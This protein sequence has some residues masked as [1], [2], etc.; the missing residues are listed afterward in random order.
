MGEA[1]VERAVCSSCGVDVWD[2]TLFCYN[3]G[4]RV[5]PGRMSEP[6]MVNGGAA[7]TEASKAPDDLSAKLKTSDAN[8]SV[9]VRASRPK[10]PRVAGVKG[11]KTVWEPAPAA[12]GTAL[13]VGSLAVAFVT[14]LVVFFVV[15]W[16]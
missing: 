7:N 14:F 9:P 5:A 1:A 10:R 2:D 6:P 16:K 3:C 8:I 11:T 13:L 12:S 15:I 4:N